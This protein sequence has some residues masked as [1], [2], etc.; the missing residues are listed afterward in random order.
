MAEDFRS[1]GFPT[2]SE[3][4][5]GLP[6][7]TLESFKD[8][9]ENMVGESNIETI[10]IFPCIVL[11]NAP[12]N[13][14]EYKEKYAIKT[15][16][17]PISLRHTSIQNETMDEF[18]NLITNTSSFNFDDLKEMHVY[19]W[20]I[21]T[22]QNLGIMQYVAKY[23]NQMYGLKFVDFYAEFLKYCRSKKSIFSEEYENL[24]EYMKI[25]YSGKGWNHFDSKIGDIN[26]PIEEASW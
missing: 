17:S 7:E 9:L 22:F 10:Y 20:A 12:M 1:Q 25:G 8:G 15:I 24:V 19:S 4:I 26:W 23:Y 3:V 16:H 21:L 13:L 14:P 6:G 18:E 11:P 2:Y 5:R